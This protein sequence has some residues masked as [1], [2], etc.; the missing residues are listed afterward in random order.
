MS[1]NHNSS[2]T[3][4]DDKDSLRI[5]RDAS[6]NIQ[7][8]YS[9]PVWAYDNFDNNGLLGG[10]KSMTYNEVYKTTGRGYNL[11]LGAIY[12]V[13]EFLRLGANYQTP[14]VLNLTDLYSYSMTTVFDGGDDVSASYP[15]KTVV[16]INKLL[17]QCV[18][19]RVSDLF[20]RKLFGYW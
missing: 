20:Y 17:R 8:T 9:Y 5:Y 2:Y 18:T 19:A 3:E 12:R 7:S 11:K 6:N 10:F 4:S 15:E 13:N 1:Y 14:T 16:F